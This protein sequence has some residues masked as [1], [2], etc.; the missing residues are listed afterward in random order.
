MG[1]KDE[2]NSAPG[3]LPYVISGRMKAHLLGLA[4]MVEKMMTRNDQTMEIDGEEVLF[5]NYVLSSLDELNAGLDEMAEG[6][7]AIYRQLVARGLWKE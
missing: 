4:D 1:L 2:I 6:M 5:K 3:S 7:N